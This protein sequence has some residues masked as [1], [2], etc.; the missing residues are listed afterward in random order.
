MLKLMREA[1]HSYPW[2]LKSFMGVIALAFVITMGWWGFRDQSGAGS[3]VASV[4]ELTV[5]HDE[6]R[7]AY[8]NTYRFYKDKVP[9]EF[10]DETIKQLVVDQLIDNRTWL[11]AA[12]NMGLTVANDDLREVIM[13]IPDFQKN[14][15]FDP[16]VYQRLLAANHLTPAI[17]EA[18]EAKEVLSNKA[19][20]IIRDAV[21]LTP[22]EL[23]EAQAL[24]LRQTESDPAKTAAAKDRAMQDVLFQKQQR[25]VMAYTEALKTTVPIKINRELLSLDWSNVL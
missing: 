8:E 17:F 25:A 6:F 14:G 5:S 23:A 11:I 15:T 20:M 16:E 19:R 18:M 12:K 10:K 3:V 13:Q 24:M 21:A 2:L 22:A 7:R 4:G 9:G 1:S